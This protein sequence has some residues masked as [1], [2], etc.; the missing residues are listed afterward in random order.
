[1]TPVPTFAVQGVVTSMFTGANTW[2]G[3]LGEVFALG[4]AISIA[5]AILGLIVYLIVSAL[6]NA[7]KGIGGK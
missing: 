6:Q 3:S 5:V 7:R 1:M 2:M 4:G